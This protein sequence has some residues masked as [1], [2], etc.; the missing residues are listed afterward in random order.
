[1]SKNKRISDDKEENIGMVGFAN[2]RR[3][4]ENVSMS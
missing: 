4:Y 2:Q 3:N 1:M